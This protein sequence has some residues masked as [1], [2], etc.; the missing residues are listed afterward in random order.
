MLKA[1]GNPSLGGRKENDTSALENWGLLTKSNIHSLC[2]SAVP[3]L[4]GCLPTRTESTEVFRRR[5]RLRRLFGT[6]LC[7]L[8]PGNSHEV[9][10]WGHA[11]APLISFS[12]LGNNTVLCCLLSVVWKFLFHVVF[13][14]SV[15]SCLRWLGKSSA[16]YSII[17]WSIFSCSMSSGGC[18]LHCGLF[19]GSTLRETVHLSFA[20]FTVSKL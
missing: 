1:Q 9:E 4:A 6:R 20:Y 10:S 17:A 16:S 11:R 15:F 18:G 3:P 5:S 12:S 7:A 19:H 14:H 13:F 2:D 8:W